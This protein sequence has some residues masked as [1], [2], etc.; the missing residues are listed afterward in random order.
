MKVSVFGLGYVGAVAAGCLAR[1]GHTVV[2]CDSNAAKVELLNAGRAPVVEAGL[3]DLLAEAVAARRLWATT[4]AAEAVA[5]SDL[6]L[7]SV[8]TPSR[9]N[10][11]LDLSAVE[12][13]AIDL[14][15]ALRDKGQD[16]AVVLRSTV[17]PGTTLGLLAP[18]LEAAAGRPVPVCFNPEFLREGSS[19][20]DFD[21]PPFTLIGADAPDLAAGVAE[22]YATVQAEVIVTTVAAAEM[23]K[24]VSN[25][26]HAVKVAF[27]N[28]IGVL[29][30]AFRVDG[31]E[32][33]GLFCRDD[34]LNIS[35]R[36][37]LPGFAFGGSCLPKDLRALLCR[38]R[39]L[40]LETPLLA[41]VLP[42]NQAQVARAAER[43]LASGRRRVSLLGLS[44]KAGTDDLRE[45]PLVALAE[46]LLGKGCE[47]R[48]YD[49]NV[50]LARLV[51]ANRAY[52]DQHLPHLGALLSD[53]LEA[54]LAHGEVVIIGHRDPALADLPA[55]CGGK[56]VL[57]LVRAVDPP[58]A[59]VDALGW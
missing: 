48:I 25:A 15:A 23:V 45:S 4:E 6:S 5:A 9:P 19:V 20:R 52:V 37:L 47:L 39:E 12:R 17:L 21:H 32:V 24:Y 35:P 18:T 53:D 40:D 3:D 8:G 49:R 30:K 1:D 11:G 34:K 28:E 33:M 50:A 51:G 56:L 29:A 16:H 26:W 58:V 10:G 13:V 38:A 36:Y 43:V 2:G 44:F 42:S 59:G 55:R 7:V 46:T 57:D 27:A 31:H 54:V 41:A 22:L 14:G